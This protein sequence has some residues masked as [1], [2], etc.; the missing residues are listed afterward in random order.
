MSDI[1]KLITKKEK[2]Y[3]LTNDLT[4]EMDSYLIDT[5]KELEYIGSTYICYEIPINNKW[6][7]RFPGATR[8]HLEV[9][10]NMIIIDIKLY[11]D[12]YNTDKIYKN[13]VRECFDKYI[14]MKLEIISQYLLK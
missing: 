12:N 5:I 7:I 8:G 9:D 4:R 6:A 10:D 14:G 2:S 11:D 13:N 3:G 1:R